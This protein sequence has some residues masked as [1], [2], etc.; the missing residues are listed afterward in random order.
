[1]TQG[2]NN[3]YQKICLGK[4]KSIWKKSWKKTQTIFTIYLEI[5]HAIN[6]LA[7]I[8]NAP[9]IFHL[10]LKELLRMDSE[11]LQKTL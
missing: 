1:M 7:V 6:V 8:V 10:H 4:R 9:T 5:V 3:F 11:Q 2:L